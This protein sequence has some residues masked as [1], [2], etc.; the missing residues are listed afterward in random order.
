M[1]SKTLM[2]FGERSKVSKKLK[3]SKTM[4][5]SFSRGNLVLRKSKSGSKSP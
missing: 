5:S 1:G 4:M 3:R 2:N